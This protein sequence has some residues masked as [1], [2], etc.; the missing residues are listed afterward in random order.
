MIADKLPQEGQQRFTKR[1]QSPNV[2]EARA[3]S[4]SPPHQQAL[5]SPK[6]VVTE[7]GQPKQLLQ[8]CSRRLNFQRLS[9][10]KVSQEAFQ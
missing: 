6:R 8:G 3:S 10:Q 7:V 5:S 1:S 2:A 9:N 4:I